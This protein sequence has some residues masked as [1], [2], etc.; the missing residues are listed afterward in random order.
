MFSLLSVRPRQEDRHHNKL[1]S[2]NFQVDDFLSKAMHLLDIVLLLLVAFTLSSDAVEVSIA[3]PQ[4]QIT[5]SI[6]ANNRL[7]S[8]RRLCDSILAIQIPSGLQVNLLFSLESTTVDL[9]M[10]YISSIE[11]PHGFKI[12]KKRMQLGGLITAVTE[13][14]FP[15]SDYDYGLLLEDDIEVSP[16]CISWIQMIFASE[17]MKDDRL[18]GISLYTPRVS[19]TL[20][21]PPNYIGEWIKVCIFYQYCFI[22]M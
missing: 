15:A 18:M 20:G 1:I 22:I 7:N 19:E 17:L 12:V 21:K 9:V 5:I 11:W 13:S 2:A 8:L 3:D 14:W 10:D 6:I 16:L 4:R